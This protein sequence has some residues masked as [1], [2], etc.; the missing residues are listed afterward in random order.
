V[1]VLVARAVDDNGDSVTSAPV[2]VTLNAAPLVALTSPA[3]GDQFAP[4]STIVLSATG[5]D[6]DG[7]LA[8][9]EFFR[10]ATSLGV[11]TTSPYAASWTSA[12]PGVYTLTARA[13]DDRGAGTTSSP[14]TV[15]VTAALAPT[16]DAEVRGSNTNTNYGPAT[17]MSVRQSSSSTNQRWS[18]LKLDLSTV[19]SVSRARLRVFGNVSATTAAVVEMAVY[20][21]SNTSWTETG[22]KWNNKPASGA[23]PLASVTIV[24]SSTAGRWYELDVT[25][26]LQQEKA[27]G[28]NVVSLVL[29]NLAN[30]SPYVSLSSRQAA[31][32]PPELIVVP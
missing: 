28:R 5:A 30:S 22:I 6:V 16:A 29:K 31:T 10:G 12:T 21:V 13:T 7:A 27:A 1:Y 9:V 3:D 8:Q 24:S 20:A 23:T 14:I 11:D 18:Y 2:S 26:Y 15:R 17:T 4:G 25:T 32:N 19:P